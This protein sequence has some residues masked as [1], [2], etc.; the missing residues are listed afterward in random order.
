ML[1]P[2]VYRVLLRQVSETKQV[3]WEV[4]FRLGQVSEF[5]LIIAYVAH[6]QGHLIG[7]GAANLIQATTIL[8]FIV[9]CYYVVMRYPTP[10][11]VSDRLRR[12]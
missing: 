5:S 11:A 7:E 1:K 2:V 8:T 10:V 3:S 4:G 9:S 6:Q 12:D